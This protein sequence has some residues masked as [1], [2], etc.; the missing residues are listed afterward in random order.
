M[1]RTKQILIEMEEDS[2]GAKIAESLNVNH[3]HL[4]TSGY[5]LKYD[6]TNEMHYIQFNQPISKELLD[7]LKA[8]GRLEN[9]NII[10]LDSEEIF[11]FTPYEYEYDSILQ[12]KDY[13]Q[14]FIHEIEDLQELNDMEVPSEKMNLILKRQIFIGIVSTMEVFFSETL[15]NLVNKNDKY[16][17][18]FVTGHPDFQ[19]KKIALKDIIEEY[20]NLSNT[21]AKTMLESVYHNMGRV[22][23]TFEKTFNIKFP[24]IE[25]VSRIVNTRH[26]LV[27]RN[28]KTKKGEVIVIDRSEVSDVIK[29]VSDFVEIIAKSL[30][31]VGVKKTEIMLDR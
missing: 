7:Q 14:N 15:I 19:K 27:H 16:F 22:K 13:Y 6:D 23:N 3:F 9:N 8:T 2:E 28:G 21:V 24:D 1:G 12:E 11:E 17:K 10:Y 29:K 25:E 18:N 30:H 26:D 31:L 5:I 20:E 4:I